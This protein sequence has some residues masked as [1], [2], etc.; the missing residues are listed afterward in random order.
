VIALRR[1]IDKTALEA[2]RFPGRRTRIMFLDDPVGLDHV[3][4]DGRTVTVFVAASN[5]AKF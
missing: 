3:D 5:W 1:K 2:I 4:L